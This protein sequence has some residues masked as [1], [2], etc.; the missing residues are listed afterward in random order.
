MTLEEITKWYQDQDWKLE[1]KG[2]EFLIT[3]GE[4]IKHLSKK[5]IFRSEFI[6]QHSR[7]EKWKAF[8]EVGASPGGLAEGLLPD[9]GQLIYVAVE[10]VPHL[11]F[12]GLFLRTDCYDKKL[13]MQRKPIAFMRMD[14]AE[15]AYLIA[16]GAADGVMID[17]QHNYTDVVADIKMWRL[18]VKKGGYLLG[19]DYNPW[20]VKN[21]SGVAYAVDEAFY[22]INLFL[23]PSGNCVWW[24]RL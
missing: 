24:L 11:K 3:K 8:I 21:A 13:G 6:L 1:D 20:G 19:H 18:K 16:P 12:Y 22:E 15:A 9:C 4:Y 7:G 17:A 10:R 5:P 2:S 23:E 14:T